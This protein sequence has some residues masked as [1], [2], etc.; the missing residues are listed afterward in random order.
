MK[1]KL[2]ATRVK[3]NIYVYQK[4]CLSYN[5]NNYIYLKWFVPLKETV[6]QI[7]NNKIL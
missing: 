7:E 6:R 4:G 1:S 5:I 3:G 2:I